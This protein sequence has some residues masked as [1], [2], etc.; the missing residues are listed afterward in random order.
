MTTLP[1]LL[2]GLFRVMTGRAKLWENARFILA[3]V[4]LYSAQVKRILPLGMRP[5]DPA[6]GTLFI[7]NYTKTS[8]TIPY[9][10]AALLIDVCTPLGRG[11]HCCWMTVD[12]D[13][14][15]IYGRELLGYPKKMAQ[16]TF[17][18]T[19]KHISASVSRRGVKLLTMEAEKGERENSPAPVFDQ[20]TFNVGAMGQ[21][22]ALN[23]VW[24]LRPRE[25]IHESYTAK[26]SMQLAES[27]YDPLATL[28]SG[29]PVSGRMAVTDIPGSSYNLPVWFAGP[30]FFNR[31]FFMR[32]R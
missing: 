14:A 29:P 2:G 16:F 17:E 25:V 22:F 10:E 20:K 6:A 30:I 28:I 4:P 7:A 26:V 32:F 19:E 13:T 24:L 5:T 27:E 1:E 8:F 12:D 31:T 23:P 15:L 21:F 11:V 3:R 18:E 9:K